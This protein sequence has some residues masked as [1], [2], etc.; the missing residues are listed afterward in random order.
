MRE[1]GREK[2]RGGERAREGVGQEEQEEA[3]EP[4]RELVSRRR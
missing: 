1:S 4:R 2:V 3:C